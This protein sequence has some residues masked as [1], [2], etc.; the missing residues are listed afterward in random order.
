M[1]F[2]YNRKTDQGKWTEANLKRAMD[3]VNV[4]GESLTSASKNYQIPY[5]TL[6]RHIKSGNYNKKLGRFTPVFTKDQEDA[7]CNY[8]KMLDNLFFG[9]TR[10]DFLQL[11]YD[12]ATQ[13]RI[14]NPFKNG[15]AGDDWFAGFK[16]RHPDIVLRSPEPT[17]IARARGFNRPQVELFYSLLWEQIEKFNF[18]A[19]FI[20]NIN[21]S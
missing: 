5:T 4:K 1:V 20:D 7:L 2:K 10:A 14:E 12:F 16:R 17:S 19:T 13:N 21:N 11:A 9:L 6:Q 3:A 18:N 8:L 15:Q